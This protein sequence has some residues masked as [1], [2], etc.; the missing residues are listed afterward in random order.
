M[1]PDPFRARY[2]RTSVLKR[3][4][5]ATGNQLIQQIEDNLSIFHHVAGNTEVSKHM[6]DNVIL[7]TLTAREQSFKTCSENTFYMMTSVTIIACLKEIFL[8]L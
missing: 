5:A 7:I 2:A 8:R 3:M 6:P 4:R 1:G